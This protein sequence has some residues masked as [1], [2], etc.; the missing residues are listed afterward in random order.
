MPKVKCRCEKCRYKVSV[1][2]EKGTQ[3]SKLESKRVPACCFHEPS[4][5]TEKAK[6]CSLFWEFGK[7]E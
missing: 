3:A 4:F 2:V 7:E 5:M 1:P 6:D